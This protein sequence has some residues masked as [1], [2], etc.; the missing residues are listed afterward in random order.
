MEYVAHF[1]IA[2]ILAA[3]L[4]PHA[5]RLREMWRSSLLSSQLTIFVAPCQS[6]APA[7]KRQTSA[8][9]RKRAEK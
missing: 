6:R 3:L 8:R 1:L 4:A 9:G 5:D 2:L 7:R